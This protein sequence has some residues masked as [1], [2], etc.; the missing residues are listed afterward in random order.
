MSSQFESQI[1]FARI[2]DGMKGRLRTVWP[3][4]EA[5]LPEILARMYDHV[6]SRPE[7]KALF[8]S[9]D[10][11]RHAQQRQREHWE[12]LFSARFDDE[13][14]LSVQRIASTHARIGLEPSFYISTYLIALEEIHQLFIRNSRHHLLGRAARAD[15]A[16]FIG[17][18]DRAVIFDLQF[19][20]T[21]YLQEQATDFRRRMEELAEQMADLLSGFTGDIMESAR[22]LNQS[23]EALSGSTGVVTNEVSL[24]LQRAEDSSANMQTVASAAE[25]ISASINEITRQTREA[26][27]VTSA[28]VDTVR[29]AGEIVDSLSAT[30][31]KIGDVVNLI[32]NIAG[33]TN[34][35]ALNATIEAAR[36]GDAGK[37]FAVVAGE[38]K[39]LSAQTAR[40]TDDIRVQVNAVQEVV[41]RIATSMTDITQA[42]DRI[43]ETT[44][45]IAG[46]VDQQ[47]DATQEITRS[48]AAAA[49]SATGFTD[50]IRR[51]EGSA[52]EN[53]GRAQGLT[54]AA[55]TMIT[56]SDILRGDT[57]V[58]IDRIR[59]A[60]RRAEM[61]TPL[62]LKAELVVDGTSH[63]ATI[64]NLSSGGAKL[65]LDGSRLAGNPRAVVLR[66]AGAPVQPEA[67]I[68]EARSG[69]VNLSFGNRRDG[70][71]LHRWVIANSRSAEARAA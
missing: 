59:N 30:A 16:A 53:A 45:S 56:R 60:D 39:T 32:Q 22:N 63:P 18:I 7:L 34:L 11:V 42:V 70:E 9:E 13:Y 19:V 57:D 44:D 33:Q 37:G 12:R 29:R 69:V 50:S 40:A 35:L 23:S 49:E 66:V 15:I 17:A 47:G 71:A 65:R 55:T 14:I 20:V 41:A 6:L 52:S 10:R 1:S 46:A 24:L 61:R 28:A 25:Q 31:L 38:V 64:N 5:G 2:D 4:V 8:A 67:T 43:R 62:S 3:M 36:A 27:D 68:V 51:I 58:L 21:T 26:A 48:V 54:Q